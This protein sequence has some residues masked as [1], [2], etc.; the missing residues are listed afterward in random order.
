MSVVTCKITSSPT[1]TLIFFPFRSTFPLAI[2]M[3]TVSADGVA[4]EELEPEVL[5]TA[6]R[7]AVDAPLVGEEVHAAKA[8]HNGGPRMRR[9]RT[10]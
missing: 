8:M 9:N 1:E 4:G 10:G 2:V 5:L 7:G 3:L 6:A